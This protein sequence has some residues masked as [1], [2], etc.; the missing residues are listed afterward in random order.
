MEW[1]T[2]EVLE[3]KLPGM[4]SPTSPYSSVAYCAY[5]H[6]NPAVGKCGD[7]YSLSQIQVSAHLVWEAT[8]VL[9]G[10]ST[11]STSQVP[12]WSPCAHLDQ[13]ARGLA[14]LLPCLS[15]SRPHELLGPVCTP[16]RG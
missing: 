16:E 12:P 14:G 6:S 9:P 8:A 11:G 5:N 10:A 1:K 13:N 15:R 2:G 3:Y 4:F 7:A